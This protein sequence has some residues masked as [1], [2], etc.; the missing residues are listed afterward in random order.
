M[1]VTILQ[2]PQPYTPSDNP[3]TWVFSSNQTAQANF[4]F[5]IEV[6]VNAVLIG[7]Y[8]RFPEVDSDTC[9]FDL[10]EENIGRIRCGK[11]I[12]DATTAYQDAGNTCTVYIKVIERYGTPATEH[13]PET[14][15]S[16]VLFKASLSD[17]DFADF[18]YSDYT[19]G[20]GSLFLTNFPRTERYYCGISENNY[21][22]F[23]NGGGAGIDVVVELFNSS[24]V[25]I[26]SDAYATGLTSQCIILNVS[27]TK[28]IANSLITSGDFATCEYYKVSMTDYLY[29]TEEFTIYVDRSC[30]NY[31]TKRLHF[32]S[33]L[34]A[35]ESFS[36]TMANNTS[37]QIIHNGYEK[38]WGGYN[39][40]NAY[41]YSNS[42][43]REVD[44]L[45][46]STGSMVVRTDFM[47]QGI[48]NWLVRELYESPY[49][50]L[51]TGIASDLKRVKVLNTGY[52]LKDIRQG[53]LISEE[54]TI[55]T[56]DVRRSALIS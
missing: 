48:Q 36:F 27:P 24:G 45:T 53:Q 52:E 39:A 3:V 50:L 11:P 18:T 8:L 51:S 35:M 12:I 40:S 20:A 6:Y 32:L 55:N 33:S 16:V 56:S 34:G 22:M 10:N 37:R 21:L 44:F 26:T 17:S 5:I 31:D 9:H 13:T 43:G 29:T 38:Q 54:V 49:V 47:E 30:D 14:S 4:S 2:N 7:R 23:L 42:Q 41:V 19:F 25:S 1:A 46:T 28:I 15:G